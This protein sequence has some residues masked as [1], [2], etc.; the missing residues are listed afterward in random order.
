MPFIRLVLV[1]A[2]LAASKRAGGGLEDVPTETL[3]PAP[4]RELEGGHSVET[5]EVVLRGVCATCKRKVKAFIQPK[6]EE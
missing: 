3:N 4:P 2:A 1:V 6:E 5:C